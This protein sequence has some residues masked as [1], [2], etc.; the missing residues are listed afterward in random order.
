VAAVHL[1][2]LS[3]DLGRLCHRGGVGGAK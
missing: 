1:G 2:I 3:D